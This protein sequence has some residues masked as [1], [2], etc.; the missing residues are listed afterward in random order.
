MSPIT[1]AWFPNPVAAHLFT[2][3]F[4]LWAISEVYNTFGTRRYRQ[5]GHVQRNDHGTYWIILLVVW[6]STAVSCL[7][8]AFHLGAFRSNLQFV[9]LGIVVLGVALREWAVLSLGRFFTVSVR[10]VQGQ[11]LIK[12]GPYRWLRHPAYSGSILSLVGFSLAIG[13]WV[14]ALLVLFLG[15][16]AYLNRVRVE[17]KALLAAYGDEYR[18]YQQQTWR[19][20]PGF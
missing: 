6:G 5:T 18:A 7:T 9:G 4:F 14:G 3:V 12:H 16:T 2:L 1:T 8:R 13:T 10:V 19:F 17:E 11:T 15:F 20:F